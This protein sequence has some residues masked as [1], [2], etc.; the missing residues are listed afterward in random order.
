MGEPEGAGR[1]SL[2]IAETDL[3]G[4]AARL[5]AAGTSHDGVGD[6]SS[7]RALILADPDGN[8]VVLTGP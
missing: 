6:V 7:G 5:T 2:V 4:V 3:D 1:S 8:R